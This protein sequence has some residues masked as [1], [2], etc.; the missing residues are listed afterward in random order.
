MT[1]QRGSKLI[2]VYIPRHIITGI[3]QIVFNDEFIAPT[4]TLSGNAT[5]DLSIAKA[6]TKEL[7]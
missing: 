7:I 5:Y 2:G 6:D 3:P 1:N 4:A